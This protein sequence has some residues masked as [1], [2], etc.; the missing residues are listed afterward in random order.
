MTDIVAQ[1]RDDIAR[2]RITSRKDLTAAADEIERLRKALRYQDDRDGRIG[3]HSP[4]CW[5]WGPRHY[6]CACAE[7]ERAVAAERE[8]WQRG[9]FICVKCGLRTES[10]GQGTPF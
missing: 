10:D 1:L 3:T 7:I 8:R 4:G 9:E 6:E 2:C 5:S